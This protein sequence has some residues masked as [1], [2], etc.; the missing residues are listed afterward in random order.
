VKAGTV[1]RPG[2]SRQPKVA[3]E[4]VDA[5]TDREQVRVKLIVDVAVAAPTVPVMVMVYAAEDEKAQRAGIVIVR[6]EESKV[7]H[8]GAPDYE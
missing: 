3:E 8:E 7:A 4:I 1:M 6:A 5:V 2:R